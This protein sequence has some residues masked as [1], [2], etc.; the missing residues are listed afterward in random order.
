[1][2]GRPGCGRR[3]R[4]RRPVR[5]VTCVGC[6][7]LRVELHLTAV[8][9]E[10]YS[11]VVPEVMVPTELRVHCRRDERLSAVVK[12][13]GIPVSQSH[14]WSEY[15]TSESMPLWVLPKEYALYV[16]RLRSDSIGTC[17]LHPDL[18]VGEFVAYF[19][20][21]ATD[22]AAIAVYPAAAIGG[23]PLDILVVLGGA[24][25]EYFGQRTAWEVVEDALTLYGGAGVLLAVQRSVAKWR[26]RRL[27]KDGR[28][29][30]HN[31]QVTRRLAR[32]VDSKRAWKCHDLATILG[33]D[34]LSTGRL[35]DR[36]GFILSEEDFATWRR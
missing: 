31:E 28:A 13:S 19:G 17:L 23:S 18:T 21:H 29:W 9:A 12:R 35:L 26:H 14:L 34:D 30:R 5:V 24:A 15:V 25:Q 10:D 22:T 2:L 11:G 3:A 36:R 7:D 27:R 33:L 6:N 1:V 20:P 16:G 8:N 4:G 32:L